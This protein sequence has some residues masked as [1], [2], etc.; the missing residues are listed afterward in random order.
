[1]ILLAE[2]QIPNVTANTHQCYEKDDFHH[3][4]KTPVKDLEIFST[5]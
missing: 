3:S 4:P 2:D 5:F 1:M